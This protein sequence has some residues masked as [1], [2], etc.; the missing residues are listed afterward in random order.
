M[1][2]LTPRLYNASNF[3][4]IKYTLEYLRANNPNAKIVATGISMGGILLAR[5][6]IDSGH[7][8][9][10]DA[11]ML[12]SVCWELLEGCANFEKPGLNLALNKQLTRSLCSIVENHREMLQQI[13]VL[14]IDK[15]LK[16]KC[17]SE[18]DKRFT[19]KMWGF[20]SVRDYYSEATSKGKLNYIKR[21]TLCINA[22]D[23]MIAPMH[24]KI[25]FR[26]LIL[27]N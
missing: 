17:L 15:V 23:D 7:D 16:S 6:L 20:E 22:A 3:D 24:S 5:Y 10:V 4:D 13:P 21:P 18:F 11:T 9:V 19:I 14:N 27:K 26:F 8:S 1:K 2:I 25:L 12:V